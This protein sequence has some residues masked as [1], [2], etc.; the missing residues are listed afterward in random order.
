MAQN[1]YLSISD[2]DTVV[3]NLSTFARDQN[4]KSAIPMRSQAGVSSVYAFTGGF[5]RVYKI[6]LNKQ[7]KALRCWHKDP[8]KVQ[9]RFPLVSDY[10]S[11]KPSPYFVDIK[12]VPNAMSYNNKNISVSL[13]EWIEGDT[14]S[15]LLE[16]NIHN[17]QMIM[18][19]ASEFLN[20]TRNLHEAKIAHGDLQTENIMVLKKGDNNL[21][22]K[23]I[24]YDSLYVPTL[25]HEHLD[26]LVGLPSFQ[27]PRRKTLSNNKSDYYKAD[28]FSELVIFLSLI[29]YVHKPS[30]WTGVKERLLF[31]STD[32]ESHGKS[33][34]FSELSKIQEPQINFL[35]EKLKEYCEL[36]PN[37]LQPLD[38][39]LSKSLKSN[40]TINYSSQDMGSFFGSQ[41][42]KPASPQYNKKKDDLKFEDA[43]MNSSPTALLCQNGHKQ[44]KVNPNDP[45]CP[46]CNSPRYFFGPAQTCPNCRNS[47][48]KSVIRFC[49]HCGRNLV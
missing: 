49:P 46:A 32:F 37:N 40:I 25:P 2:Y 20:M 14:L 12:Y 47:V 19:V 17:K 10:L 24:D 44:P 7:Y 35:A 23:L 48:P 1:I 41:P 11:E 33:T 36:L 30:L 3:K 42:L 38:N 5:S 15:K 18:I 26:D 21:A 13:M 28:Y 22:L 9:K 27:H 31:E 8:G 34:I 43:I 4:L 45:Y 6:S 16:K 39:L 29:S